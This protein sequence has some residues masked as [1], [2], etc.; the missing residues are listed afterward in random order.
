MKLATIKELVMFLI[1]K[2]SFSDLFGHYYLYTDKDEFLLRYS[3]TLFAM[4]GRAISCKK[5]DLT[6]VCVAEER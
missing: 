2:S 5:P 1:I 3:A 4:C 6:I